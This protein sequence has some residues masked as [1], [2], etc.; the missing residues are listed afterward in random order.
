VARVLDQRYGS[1]ADKARIALRAANRVAGNR[2]P[3]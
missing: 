2:A 3:A 1:E